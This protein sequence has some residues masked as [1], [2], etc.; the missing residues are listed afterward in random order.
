MLNQVHWF[1]RPWVCLLALVMMTGE[2]PCAFSSAPDRDAPPACGGLAVVSEP[3]GSSVLVDGTPVGVTPLLVE[4]LRTGQHRVLLVKGGYLT[5][6][7]DVYVSSGRTTS[8]RT[9]LTPLSQPLGTVPAQADVPEGEKKNGSKLKYIVPAGIAAI[10]GAVVAYKIATKNEPPVAVGTISPTATGLARLTNYIFDGSGSRDPNKDNVTYVWDFGD[11]TTGSGERTTKR[12][13]RPGAFLVRLT[14]SDG[15]L[16]ST[17]DVGSIN[18]INN[19]EG[20]WVGRHSSFTNTHTLII[21]SQG[22]SPFAGTWTVSGFAGR[23]A[24]SGTLDGSNNYVCPCTVT[25]SG[26]ESSCPLSM[27]F[28]GILSADGR[29]LSGGGSVT[30]GACSTIRGRFVGSWVLSR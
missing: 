23:G 2:A 19:L 10:G 7:R 25:M 24:M 3:P 16:S 21:G 20:T 28:T 14:V 18:V 8:L 26:T 1:R 13:D 4:T 30:Y 29:S 6:K 11:G 22:A 12:F 9:R 17:V 15:K 5:Q 27:D